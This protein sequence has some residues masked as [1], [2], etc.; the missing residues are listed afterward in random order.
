MME[1]DKRG[2]AENQH[3]REEIILRSKIL[4]G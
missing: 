4:I 3:K 2:R 1:R